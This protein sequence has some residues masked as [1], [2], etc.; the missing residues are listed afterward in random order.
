MSFSAHRA[1]LTRGG[2]PFLWALA[3]IQ[4]LSKSSSASTL[5]GKDIT[6]VDGSITMVFTF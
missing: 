3:S 2:H 5:F 1:Y 6:S 4:Y